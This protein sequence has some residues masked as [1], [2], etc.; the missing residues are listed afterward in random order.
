M[1]LCPRI[2][3]LGKVQ[4]SGDQSVFG[5]QMGSSVQ[6]CLW[7]PCT[8]TPVW[9]S[10]YSPVSWKALLIYQSKLVSHRV[11]W[12][13][14]HYILKFWKTFY[15]SF[16]AYSRSIVVVLDA[17]TDVL[18]TRKSSMVLTWGGQGKVNISTL[19]WS[20]QLNFLLD[21]SPL[22][23]WKSTV[24]WQK[25]SSVNQEKNPSHFVELNHCSEFAARHSNNQS[26]GLA[27]ELVFS[28]G[29]VLKVCSTPHFTVENADGWCCV[30]LF[31]KY[32]DTVYYQA[33][34]KYP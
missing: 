21:H 12:Q 1:C 22:K 28:T 30:V 15:N 5:W 23:R 17:S 32:T 9:C 7:C 14:Q 11:P 24:W 27:N 4:F 16:G 2:R 20:H 31:I 33:Y 25:W 19:F 10:L 8:I 29:F 6:Q 18:Q 3:F 26:H 13:T 34:L